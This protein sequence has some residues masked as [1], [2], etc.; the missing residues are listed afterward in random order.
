MTTTV[1]NIHTGDAFDVYIGRPGRGF[2]GYFGNPHAHGSRR[3]NV[4]AFKSYFAKRVAEDPE[5]RARVLALKGKILGCH[6]APLLC[7]GHIMAAWIDSQKD[8]LA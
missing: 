5:Y 4:E 1:V 3:A 7:H 6:C 2:D 8:D